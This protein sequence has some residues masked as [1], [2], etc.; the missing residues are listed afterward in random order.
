MKLH[1]MHGIDVIILFT[2]SRQVDIIFTLPF[3]GAA[4]LCIG[5]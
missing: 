5:Q 2:H 4:G 1:K 3:H